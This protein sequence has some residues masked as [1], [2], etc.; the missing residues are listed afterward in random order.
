LKPKG[1][2]ALF[3]VIFL[4]S[5]AAAETLS[6]RVVSVTDGDTATILDSHQNQHKIRLNGIDAP[7]SKQDSATK[8]F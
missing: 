4:A 3:L 8:T 5:I 6:G 2:P 7:E 1:L